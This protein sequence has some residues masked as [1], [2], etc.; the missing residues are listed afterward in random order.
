MGNGGRE[1]NA[2]ESRLAP[3]EPK[4]LIGIVGNVAHQA[5]NWF[6]HFPT[7]DMAIVEFDDQGCCHDRTQML[8]LAKYISDLDDAAKDAIVIVFIHGWKHDARSDDDNVARFRHVLEQ[9]VYYENE[10]AKNQA[11]PPTSS[12]ASPRRICWL[13][14]NVAL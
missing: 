4:S 8:G 5:P 2:S 11:P 1:V 10:Q 7:Y 13:A 12:E 3:I 14:G 6:F 9:A